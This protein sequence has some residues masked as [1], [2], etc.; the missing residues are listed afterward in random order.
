MTG[1]DVLRKA[2]LM[3][4]MSEEDYRL[5]RDSTAQEAAI[6]SINQVFGEL[7]GIEEI[8]ELSEEIRADKQAAATAVYGVAA[9]LALHFGSG[10]QS[11]ILGEF[12]LSHRTKYKARIAKIADRMPIAEEVG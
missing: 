11:R 12:Y 9:L 8:G 2:L 3:L 7:A 10:E 6:I 4:G 5:K 1:Y